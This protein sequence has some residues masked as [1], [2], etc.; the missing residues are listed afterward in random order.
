MEHCQPGIVEA[1]EGAIAAGVRRL[2]V[3]P[4]FISGGGHVRLHVEPLLREL[5]DA[6]PE[7]EIRML[8]ALAEHPRVVDVLC[9]MAEG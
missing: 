6:H 5:A 1:V 7:A 3:L 9:E 4:L 8:P 2:D